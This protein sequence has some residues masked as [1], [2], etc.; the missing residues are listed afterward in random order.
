MT[1]GENISCVTPH[2][3]SSQ[4]TFGAVVIQI[5]VVLCLLT[6]L[7][8]YIYFYCVDIKRVDKPWVDLSVDYS[9]ISTYS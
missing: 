4:E 6:C 8:I 9:G 2:T 7:N 1:F 3:L 5:Y